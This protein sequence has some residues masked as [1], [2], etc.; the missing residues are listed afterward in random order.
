[1]SETRTVFG[2]TV[3]EIVLHLVAAFVAG[4][5]TYALTGDT[6]AGLTSATIGGAWFSL[7]IV[8]GYG[9]AVQ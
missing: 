5:C 7:G 9:E 2:F 8:Y 1:M 6:Y 3:K 4:G